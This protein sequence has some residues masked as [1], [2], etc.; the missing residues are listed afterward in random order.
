MADDFTTLNPGSGG[1]SMDEEGVTYGSA[2]VTRKRTRVRIAGA[3]ATDLAPVTAGPFAGDAIGLLTR[4]VGDVHVRDTGNEQTTPLLAAAVYTGTFKRI[5][6]FPSIFISYLTNVQ[7]ASVVVQWSAD[8]ITPEAGSLGS[9]TLPSILKSG[10]WVTLFETHTPY[11]P[12]YRLVVTNGATPQAL[13]FALNFLMPTNFTGQFGALDEP[14]STFSVALLTRAVQAGVNPAGGF[15]TR[16]IDGI[17]AGNNST[18][19]LTAGSTFTGTGESLLGYESVSVYVVSDQAGSLFFDTSTDGVNWETPAARNYP[20]GSIGQGYVFT[21]VSAFFRVRFTNTAAVPQTVFRMQTIMR[22]N[23]SGPIFSR[24][25]TPITDGSLAAQERA[26]IAGKS[27]SGTYL[28][29]PTN[30]IGYLETVSEDFIRDVA[31]GRVAGH[32]IER[33]TS[34]NDAVQATTEEDI[35][36]PSSAHTYPAAAAVVSIV[37]A[38]AL[39]TIAGTG[40]RQVR[41]R[42]LNSSFVI[43]E[44][45]VNLNG[46]VPVVT[47]GTF[48]RVFS[49]TAETVGSGGLAAGAIT[50]TQTTT[51]AVIP[52]NDT[53]S[54]NSFFT[55][56]DLKTAVMVNLTAATGNTDELAI[57][58]RTR[59]L[60]VANSPFIVRDR[61]IMFASTMERH[62][63]SSRTFTQHTDIKWSAFSYSGSGKVAIHYALLLIDNALVQ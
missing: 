63:E 44:E 38:S 2:P 25:D 31:L 28:N 14:L 8:G 40:V 45:V 35:W 62:I 54:Y 49:I 41:V 19:L 27:P 61:F 53:Q 6:Q 58:L 48:I 59:D 3:A 46:L 11:R 51:Q 36:N 60:T 24:L 57:F 26:V 5:D 56:P 9:Q 1:S 20:G 17:S 7:P 29:V 15:A 10:L 39:D 23:P 43:T 42:G 50:A 12:Y 52:I 47:T 13:V 18:T 32:S 37:S 4:A 16:P 21:P 34:I 33:I 55:V 22:S 30:F